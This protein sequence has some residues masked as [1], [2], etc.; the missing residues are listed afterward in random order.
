MVKARPRIQALL[1]TATLLTL[2]ALWG[3]QDDSW[4]PL[5]QWREDD[6]AVQKND[7]TM[8]PLGGLLWPGNAALLRDAQQQSALAPRA[9][10]DP[11]DSAQPRVDIA[12]FLPPKLAPKNPSHPLSTQAPKLL[13]NVSAEY[14]QACQSLPAEQ[15]LLDPW[16]HLAETTGEELEQFLSYHSESSSIRATALLLAKGEQ[17]PPD[18]DLGKLASGSLTR[19]KSCLVV[20]PLGEPWRARIFL[21]QDVQAS[22]PPVYLANLAGDCIS[23]ATQAADEGDQLHR[24]LV[25]LS[26][27]LFWLERMLPQNVAATVGS[28]PAASEQTVAD[29]ASTSA[30]HSVLM[31]ITDLKPDSWWGL[32]FRQAQQYQLPLGA[33][34]LFLLALLCYRRW[35]AYRMRHYEWILPER[36]DEPALLGAEFTSRVAWL[37]Y[38]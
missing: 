12:S 24:F 30:F 2:S 33:V 27:R 21:S 38:R 36:E 13:V 31:E 15:H 25:R 10:A 6:L 28:S 37:S 29:S 16:H 8:E 32:L 20:L 4:I 3:Q 35:S 23:D 17:L 1:S 34:A 18:V 5:P 11:G 14:L 19:A 26:T 22:V 7:Q 9:I